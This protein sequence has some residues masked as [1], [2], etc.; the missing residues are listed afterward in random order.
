M[1]D[2]TCARGVDLLM[3]YLEGILPAETKTAI[4][5]HLAGCPRCVAFVASYRETPRILRVATTTE[6]PAEAKRML[7]SF[8][9]RLPGRSET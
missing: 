5:R 1:S 9:K 7:A 2:L 3:E 4:D 6:I 8:V